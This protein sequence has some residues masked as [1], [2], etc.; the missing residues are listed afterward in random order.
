ML[1]TTQVKTL[2]RVIIADDDPTTAELIADN[3]RADRYDALI[4][5]GAGEVVDA[6]SDGADVIVLDSRLRSALDLLR[7]GPTN[8]QP[9]VIMVGD[10]SD[11]DVA[12][13]IADGA[14][15]YLQKPFDYPELLIRI[16]V[17]QRRA[18]GEGF[19]N[20]RYTLGPLVVDTGTRQAT[21]DGERIVL[22]TK[23]FEILATLVIDPTRVHTKDELLQ[24]I[25]GYRPGVPTRTLDSHMS[26][27]RRK[28]NAEVDRGFVV[29]CWG[30]GFRLSPEDLG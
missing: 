2:G 15:D 10:G 27:L 16:R 4:A 29:N 11:G 12:H 17:L 25:W 8:V 9:I 6:C 13:A 19:H 28:L 1:Q 24:G 23:E 22:T 3:L 5:A 20:G 18:R 21:L 7:M 30:V 14:E 26:R